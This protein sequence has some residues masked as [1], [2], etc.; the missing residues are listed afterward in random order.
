MTT[1]TNNPAAVTKVD[2]GTVDQLEQRITAWLNTRIP[3]LKEARVVGLR[4]S[5]TSGLS[6]E[7]YIVD[8]QNGDAAAPDKLVVKK[9]VTEN[10]TN[11]QTSFDNL[12][13]LQTVLGGVDGL[14]I[15]RVLGV[16]TASAAIGAPFLVMEYVEGD[17]PSDVPCYATTGFV[18]DATVE[19]RRRMWQSGIDFLVRLHRIDWREYELDRLRFDL[20]GETELDRCV[21]HAISMFRAEA[22]G[23]TAP[24]CELAI[25]WLLANQPA[26]QPESICWGDARIGNMIWRDFNCVA[27]I[28]WEM[29]SLGSPAVDLGWWSFFHR[30]S[31]FGQG[32]PDLDGMCVGQPLADLYEARGGVHIDN[33]RYFEVLA[34]VRGLSIWLRTY[35]AMRAAGALPADMD[36]LGESIHMIR[37]LRALMPED[38]PPPG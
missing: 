18:H 19:Q 1:Q 27:V 36:P 15:P 6:G 10:R 37:V 26:S 14:P 22:Q 13:L 11:P 30:W 24:T 29:C 4:S 20:P 21:S 34:A 9:D 35:A 28:D 31:T 23:R 12:V 32:N 5:D 33:F 3:D 2:R 38:A 8:V 17:I 7:T 25:E 16:E